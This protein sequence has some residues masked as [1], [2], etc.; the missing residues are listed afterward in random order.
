M[1]KI[2]GIIFDIDGVLYSG[3][4]AVDG[5][6]Y[7][8]NLIADAKIPFRCLSNTIR[9]SSSLISEKLKDFGFNIPKENIITSAGVVSKILTLMNIKKCFFLVTEDVC[10]DFYSSGLIFDEINPEA[11]VIGDEGHNFYYE[12]LNR[13]FRI[14]IE[15]NRY[16]K[17]KSLENNEIFFRK[18]IIVDKNTNKNG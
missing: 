1:K 13:V 10:D 14:L 17:N 6:C 3:E 18:K 5:T 4:E 2:A 12:R 8:L 7:A 11:V 16:N 9:K 15:I